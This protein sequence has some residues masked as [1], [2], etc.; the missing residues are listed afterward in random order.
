[1]CPELPDL[2]I[3]S[4]LWAPFS[5]FWPSETSIIVFWTFSA[6]VYCRCCLLNTIASSDCQCSEWLRH[7]IIYWPSNMDPPPFWLD[8][9]HSPLPTSTNTRLIRGC[10]SASRYQ[11]GW[12]LGHIQS[13]LRNARILDT[14]SVEVCTTPRPCRLIKPCLDAS[15]MREGKWGLFETCGLP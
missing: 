5:L 7:I 1:M 13:I 8:V 6:R 11:I 14:L 10:C 2:F 15:C 9:S 12:R 4:P 3:F